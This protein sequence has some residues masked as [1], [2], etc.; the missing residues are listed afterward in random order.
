MRDFSFAVS[1]MTKEPAVKNWRAIT[2]AVSGG[3][4]VTLVATIVAWL[5]KSRQVHRYKALT[6]NSFTSME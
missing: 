3:L 2:A 6:L 4:F 1:T 5:R